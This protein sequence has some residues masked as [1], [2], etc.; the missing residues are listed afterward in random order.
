L[1]PGALQQQPPTEARW[2]APRLQSGALFDS[3]TVGENVGFL[4]HEHTNLPQ[5]RIKVGPGTPDGPDAVA[6]S[7]WGV[8]PLSCRLA[9]ACRSPRRR[10]AL[11]LI[12]LCLC[13]LQAWPASDQH[14]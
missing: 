3:L 10:H 8:C 6:A 9:R 2:L 13:N 4:L 1:H 14:G 7:M 11:M 12:N 5:P